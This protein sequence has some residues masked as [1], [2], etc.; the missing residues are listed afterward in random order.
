M[1]TRLEIHPAEG[2]WVIRAGGAVIGETSRALEVTEGGY[3]PVLYIPREDIAM[4][5]LDESR[6]RTACPHK[7]EARYFTLV[8]KSGPVPD[9]AWSYET[10]ANGAGALTGHIAFYADKVTLERI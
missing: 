9:V 5:L 4:A 8:T 10:P 1:P 2:T 7:G 6:T 3:P